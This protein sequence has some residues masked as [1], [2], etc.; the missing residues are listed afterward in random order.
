MSDVSGTSSAQD[1]ISSGL[2][3]Q[4]IMLISESSFL[5]PPVDIRKTSPSPSI[6]LVYEKNLTSSMGMNALQMKNGGITFLS[7]ARTRTSCSK[8]SVPRAYILGD[9]SEFMAE[10]TR[11]ISAPYAS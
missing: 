9:G 8:G 10:A 5:S 4:N 7:I 1:S 2:A 3:F 11:I 6:G